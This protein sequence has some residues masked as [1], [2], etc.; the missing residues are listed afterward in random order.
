MAR[1]LYVVARDRM[2]LYDRFRGELAREADIDVVLDR[3]FGER[4]RGER[5]TEG[6]RGLPGRRRGG[7]RRERRPDLAQELREV[8]YFIATNEGAGARSI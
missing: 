5:R 4:R 2:D 1:F 7:E 8:G 3:R 6:G